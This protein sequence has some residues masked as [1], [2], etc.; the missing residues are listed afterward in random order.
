MYL[1]HAACETPASGI[2]SHLWSERERLHFVLIGSPAFP[3]VYVI[4]WEG[5]SF[6]AYQMEDDVVRT[7]DVKYKITCTC[8]ARA[9]DCVDVADCI[10]NQR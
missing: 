2:Y 10:A 4:L 1:A 3:A 7:F 9:G 5:T 6:R 8:P